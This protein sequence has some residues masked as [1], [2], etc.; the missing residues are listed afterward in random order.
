M[1]DTEPSPPAQE[2]YTAAT[3]PP[4]QNSAALE[5]E[6]AALEPERVE[7]LREAASLI[8]VEREQQY[9]P[10]AKNLGTIAGLWSQILG[11]DITPQQ[12]ALC[13]TQLKVARMISGDN[14]LRD[15]YTDAAGYLAL[16][17]ELRDR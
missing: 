13:M 17:W 5:P 4:R 7:V 14:N 9:G 6:R 3:P 15:N 2:T 10:P 12:V 16:A 1:T 8:S 11:I